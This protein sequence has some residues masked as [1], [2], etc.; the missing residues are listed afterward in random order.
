ML[1]RDSEQHLGWVKGDDD[2][3]QHCSDL[4]LGD[5]EFGASVVIEGV[6]EGIE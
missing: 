4:F 5:C 2:C 1:E 6:V 3:K